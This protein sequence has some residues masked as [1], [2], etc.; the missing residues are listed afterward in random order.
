MVMHILKIIRRKK[1]RDSTAWKPETKQPQRAGDVSTLAQGIGWDEIAAYL[2][3]PA[4][5]GALPDS[6]S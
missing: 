6:K 1:Q 5:T 2:S 3:N 4:G